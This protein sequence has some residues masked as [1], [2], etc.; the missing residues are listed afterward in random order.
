[1]WQN[2]VAIQC[3]VCEVLEIDEGAGEAVYI[4]KKGSISYLAHPFALAWGVTK[5]LHMFVT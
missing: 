1:V 3:K 2:A 5:L 4:R